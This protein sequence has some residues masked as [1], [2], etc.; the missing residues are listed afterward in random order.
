MVAVMPESPL[1]T[2]YTAHNCS[3]C[4]DVREVLEPLAPE[5]SLRVEWVHIDGD[6]ELEARWREQIPVG[7]LEGRR[8]FKYRVNEHQLRLRVA[9]HRGDP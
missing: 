4:D 9:R 5:L 2:V 6:P 1:L 8:V 7:V 3:L